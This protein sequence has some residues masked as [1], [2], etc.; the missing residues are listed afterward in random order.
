MQAQDTPFVSVPTCAAG[1]RLVS[2][3]T[4]LTG[5]CVPQAASEVVA[6]HAPCVGMPFRT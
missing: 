2:I 3:F 1:E 4:T 6:V 5:Q